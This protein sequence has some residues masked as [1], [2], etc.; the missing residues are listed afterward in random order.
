MRAS[1]AARSTLST[2]AGS[3]MEASL[4]K[5]KSLVRAGRRGITIEERNSGPQSEKE[6]PTL[7]VESI[8]QD[9]PILQRTIHGKPLIYLDNAAT[10]QK[11]R[12]VTD[13]LV[14]YYHG[15][16]ANVHRSIHTLGDEATTRYENAREKT[17]RFINAP[18]VES[19]V[20]TRNATE[21]INL[22]A[23]TWGFQHVKEGDEIVLSVMEHHSNLIPW[24]MLAKTNGVVLRFIDIDEEGQL[25]WDDV[26]RLINE[27][28]KLVALTQMSNVLGTI[29]PVREIA[30]I[31]HAYGAL[32]LVDGAQSVPH[33]PVDVQD[34]DCD[35]LAFSSHKMLGPMGIGI[36]Y[37]RHS[38]LQKMGPFLGGGHM[39]LHVELEHA[40]Y[41]AAPWRWE[42]GTPDI[43]GVYA[44]GA[45]LD[46]L[47]GL[48]M[49]AVRQHDVDLLD[50]ALRSLQ[51]IRGV[52]V[53][54]PHDAT[55]RGGALAFNFENV[56]GHDVGTV[57]DSLGIMVRAGHHCAQPLMKR[58]GVEATSRASFY[59]YNRHEEV[60][61]LAEGIRELDRLFGDGLCG[62]PRPAPAGSGGLL[63][64]DPASRR[65]VE[66]VTSDRLGAHWRK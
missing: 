9:F 38:V 3:P 31:A 61:A 14:E 66:P 43:G 37:A 21:A 18:T 4:A 63:I 19:I 16:N 60:D 11:P 52:T 50:H 7:D 10:S 34:L 39:I 24:Q 13:A 57:L 48:G 53:Y 25:R 58:L 15:H 41:N 20:F 6:R 36:L 55:K 46:Y 17:R 44:F 42:A 45:A 28:T 23:Y 29:N 33:M 2:P 56:H 30:K 51:E 1:P 40:T 62:L 65:P 32:M 5:R 27:K 54:G 8:R 22:V 49:E 26:E 47:Q 64:V 12:V 59:V 35:F